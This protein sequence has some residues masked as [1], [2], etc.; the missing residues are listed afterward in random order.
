[1]RLT[2]GATQQVGFFIPANM[3]VPADSVIHRLF[4][5]EPQSSDSAIE[6]LSQWESRGKSLEAGGV[7]V[8]ARKVTDRVIAIVQPVEKKRTKA[9]R[10]HNELFGGI[11]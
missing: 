8:E 9:H 1:M 3:R 5:A 11:E 10:H 4:G 6:N 7:V 2:T